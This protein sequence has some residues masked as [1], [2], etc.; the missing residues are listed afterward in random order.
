MFYQE[1][2]GRKLGRY[3]RTQ[4]SKLDWRW[5]WG[6]GGL[7]RYSQSR[8]PHGSRLCLVLFHHFTVLS[9]KPS[10]GERPLG[11]VPATGMPVTNSLIHKAAGSLVTGRSL[12]NGKMSMGNRRTERPPDPVLYGGRPSGGFVNS[13]VR[14]RRLCE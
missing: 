14:S 5:G 11:V 3:M 8:R 10:M 12:K 7:Q 9:V 6:G 13:A 4:D 2:N 1:E